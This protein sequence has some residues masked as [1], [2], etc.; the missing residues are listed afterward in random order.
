MRAILN[1][2]VPTLIILAFSIPGLLML[3]PNGDSRVFFD[4]NSDEYAKVM[5]LEEEFSG[6][7]TIMFVIESKSGDVFEKDM[8]DAIYELTEKLWT[9]SY[10]QKVDS[11]THFNRT[12]TIDDV[13]ETSPLYHPEHYDA[14]DFDVD[15]IRRYAKTEDRLIHSLL[16]Q[17]LDVTA[18]VVT[19]NIERSNPDQ[20]SEVI[21]WARTLS[22]N[23]DNQLPN[24]S[25]NLAGTTVYAN[26]LTEAT[27]AE[28]TTKIPLIF[29]LMAVVL[30]V[31]LRNV[32]L[33]IATLYIIVITIACTL[34]IAGWLGVPATPI[35]AFVPVALFA[36]VLADAV[37]FITGY[38]Y[39][40]KNVT[41][42]EDAIAESIKDN[43]TPMLVT[44]LTTAVG[45]LCLNV[46][47]SPPYIHFGNLAAAGSV[48][49][50]LFTVLWMP[51]WIELIPV[52]SS[53]KQSTG[54]NSIFM[55]AIR[56]PYTSIVLVAAVVLF[57]SLQLPKNYLD[58]RIDLYFDD[59]WEISRTNSL[60]ND[61]LTGIHRL[62]YRVNTY[63]G[64]TIT[65]PIYLDALSDFRVWAMAQPN[66]ANVVSFEQVIKTINQQMNE[67][68]SEYYKTPESREL[69]SQYLLL[70]ELSL[71]FGSNI[72]SIVNFDKSATRS[73]VVLYSSSSR[74]IIK[75]EEDA[76]RWIRN[77]WPEQMWADAIS[78][79]AAFASLNIENSYSLITSTIA[80]FFIIALILSIVLRSWTLGMLSI[81]SNVLP[82]VTAFGFWGLLDGQIGLAVSIVT[83]ITLGIVVDDTIHLLSKYQKAKTRLKLSSR[84]AAI[85][86]LETTGRALYTTTVVLVLCF[87]TLAFSHFK[88]NADLGL[89]CALTLAIALIIDLFMFLPL[90]MLLGEKREV[91]NSLE[92]AK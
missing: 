17:G 16:G 1:L 42:K 83:V 36:I 22:E 75:F 30:F 33:V 26:A 89:L 9:M 84:N 49:A 55:V 80:G 47:N 43:F 41:T 37:H 82:A 78:L 71:P 62:E 67:G 63:D 51:K 76:S 92:V 23:I 46:S 53:I 39:H 32:G 65:S 29:L 74:E 4:K 58:E 70:Y 77:N 68:D 10:V 14:G 15:A 86:A 13:L 72:E 19:L 27:R 34:G 28:F 8:L 59:S 38:L 12:Q 7:N 69:A 24:A 31:I 81:V 20:V 56:K 5:D 44:S 73:K 11:L 60:I 87:G 2:L 45:F 85:Y 35:M 18:V 88:P 66:V 40:I 21:G 57:S 64:I 54:I 52:N 91:L 48:I 3:K 25:V 6:N 79:E 61:K 50:F 90:V